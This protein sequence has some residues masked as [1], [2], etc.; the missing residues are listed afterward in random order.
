[1]GPATITNAEI[2]WVEIEKRPLR[3]YAWKNQ[4]EKKERRGEWRPNLQGLSGELDA[5]GRLGV[6]R[7]VVASEA[8]EDV[9]LANTAV[10]DQHHLE[11]I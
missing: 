11:Q 1:M 4:E 9:G 8:A 10:P 2:W 3:T 5:D 7:E 6:E